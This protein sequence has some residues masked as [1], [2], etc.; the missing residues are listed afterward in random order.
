MGIQKKEVSG[1]HKHVAT[2]GLE[3]L[4][5]HFEAEEH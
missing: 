3:L 1:I 2:L 4:R 5:F